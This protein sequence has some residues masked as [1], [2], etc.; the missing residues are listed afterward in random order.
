MARARP[1]TH[2]ARLL[3]AL[4]HQPSD[5][6]PMD[7]GTTRTTGATIPAYAR[8]RTH[9]G[10]AAPAQRPIVCIDV[11]QQ[12]ALVEDDVQR[13][14]DVDA[15]GVF[16]GAPDGFTTEVR[17][18]DGAEEYTDEWGIRRRRP[19]G[20]HYFDLVAP[21]LHGDP[22]PKRLDRYPWPDPADPGRFRTLRAQVDALQHEGEYAIVVN[23]TYGPIHL[24]QY[25][26]GFE[27]WFIDLIAEPAF[28]T[29]LLERVF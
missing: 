5:R 21:P 9:L 19:A 15:R 13:A 10:L 6:V 14:L 25:L 20:G 28:A 27:D 18:V 3:A 22:D 24:T 26:R 16:L 8:L 12:L 2:R 1:G 29:A 7:F 23:P 17:S 4:A 11:M